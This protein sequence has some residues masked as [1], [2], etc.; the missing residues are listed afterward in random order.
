MINL[1]ADNDSR[2][3]FNENGWLLSAWSVKVMLPNGKCQKNIISLFTHWSTDVVTEKCW[4]S[5]DV[6]EIINEHG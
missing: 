6:E 2:D 3:I 1:F 4:Q 5:N